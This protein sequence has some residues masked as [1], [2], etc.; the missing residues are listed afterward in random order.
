MKF[1]RVLLL[2][3]VVAVM[4]PL[5]QAGTL[6][7]SNATYTGPV[8]DLT[9]Y[10]NGSYNF[11]FGPVSLP[12]GITFNSY[13]GG[14]NS[15][16]GSVVGQGFYG[17]L[18][19]GSFDQN[20]VYIGLDSGFNYMEFTFANPVSS[21]GGFMNYAVCGGGTDMCGY[22]DPVISTYDAA[23]NL[24]SSFDLFTLA[25]IY[26][27]G[28]LDQFEFRGIDENSADIKY[29]RIAGGY[30]LITATANGNL[31]GVPEPASMVLFGSG[32]IGLAG[33]LRRK[34]S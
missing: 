12:G 17:L 2:L 8:L 22:D 6:L 27:P 10:A 1:A 15:G 4:M 11:T 20:P 28:G 26:T 3:L 14:G 21:F 13:N 25:P 18:D 7:T 34:L 29:F 5:A 33:K 24:L 31:P 9:A 16:L 30:T 23:H 32:L 19:N